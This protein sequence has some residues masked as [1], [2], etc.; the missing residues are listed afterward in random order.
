MR[1]VK[2]SV[3]KVLRIFALCLVAQVPAGTA[4]T[5]YV[6]S[7]Q[8]N[9]ANSGT[10]V[11]APWQTLS[12]AYYRAGIGGTV[13]NPGD[14]LLFKAGDSFEGP[15]VINQAGTK[16]APITIDRYGDGPKPI[17]Y[18]DHSNAVWTAV[19]GHAG[20]YSA[21]I[22]HT[23]T[24]GIQYLYDINGVKYYHLLQGVSALGD[25]LNTFTNGCWGRVGYTVY[26]R[27]LDNNPPPRM[28]LFSQCVLVLS[29]GYHLVQNLELCRG[30][31]GIVC[32]GESNII[33][34]ITVRDSFGCGI[35][36]QN[37]I[38]TLV[39][40]NLVTGTAYT[41]YYLDGGGNNIIRY[42]TGISNDSRILG[43]L[44][45]AD[46]EKSGV[47]LKMGTNNLIEHN[48][49]AYLSS[50]FDYYYEVNTT[51]RYNY[52]F[53]GMKG[54]SPSGTGLKFY[55]NIFDLDGV[56][57]GLSVAHAYDATYSPLPDTGTNLVYNNTIY[58][59]RGYAVFSSTNYSAGGIIRNNVFI[60]PRTNEIMVMV[61]QP[62][63]MDYNI[64]YCPGVGGWSWNRLA[65]PTFAGFQAASG[66]EK[67]GIYAN[68]QL[69]SDS[70]VIAADFKLK[71]TSPCIN[72]GQDLRGVGLLGPAQ[73][74]RDYI[75]TLIPQGASP[76]IG[77][78]E[79]YWLDP[80]S[81]LT[82]TPN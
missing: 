76:D 38:G 2:L 24:G 74:Y 29:Y 51:V 75:G 81:N 54:A 36:T 78:Y 35:F 48:S 46:R 73:E 7:S 60:T 17:I 25:W 11:N 66:Q 63:D 1:G 12:N 43:N 55:N 56:G 53:H 34:N 52:G 61:H 3:S 59:F 57:S 4:A 30:G 37:G 5:Y 27:T 18:G 31:H 14:S 32:G 39:E 41:M 80:P 50:F 26:I 10:S 47:G 6:S 19:G 40:S 20:V 45:F 58:N 67:H 22:G 16:E 8:G 33:R 71:P 9:D 13:F 21:E 28:Y 68:P 62:L 64:Y 70:P 82:V 15:L 49:F 77:P 42:N 65:F 23:G 69:I 79:R 72:A 44:V